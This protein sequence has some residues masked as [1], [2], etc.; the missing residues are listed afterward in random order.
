MRIDKG[1]VFM[2]N[3]K[4][5]SFENMKKCGEQIKSLFNLN[6]EDIYKL[7]ETMQ[8]QSIKKVIN[9]DVAKQLKY[10]K[11][12]ID[13][14]NRNVITDEFLEKCRKASQLFKKE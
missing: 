13:E 8:N 9:I 10:S 3:D 5:N 6:E 7:L 11:E 2:E 12:F 4:S 1:G 14:W